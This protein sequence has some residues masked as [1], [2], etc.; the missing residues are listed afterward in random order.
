M[1]NA[2]PS[3][4]TRL[5]ADGGRRAA[6]ATQHGSGNGQPAVEPLTL[7]LLFNLPPLRTHAPRRLLAIAESR[8]LF[9]PLDQYQRPAPD[10]SSSIRSQPNQDRADSNHGSERWPEEP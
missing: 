1:R 2:Q 5:E 10:K 7:P 8:Q 4:Q 9:L 3:T 6:A